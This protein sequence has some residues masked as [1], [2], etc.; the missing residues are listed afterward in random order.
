MGTIIVKRS[1]E[2]NMNCVYVYTSSSSRWDNVPKFYLASNLPTSL[3]NALECMETVIEWLCIELVL[4]GI[5]I[6]Y[7]IRGNPM[8]FCLSDSL[9]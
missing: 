7:L 1:I 8:L 4:N 5:H 6:L 2:C 3:Q 9:A